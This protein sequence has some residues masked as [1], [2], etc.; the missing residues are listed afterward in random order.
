MPWQLYAIWVDRAECATIRLKPVTSGML[1]NEVMAEYP[2]LM[3]KLR[4]LHAVKPFDVSELSEALGKT[5]SSLSKF[6]NHKTKTLEGDQ[7]TIVESI[8]KIYNERNV[9]SQQ[10]TEADFKE[11]DIV[12]FGLQIGLPRTDIARFTGEQIPVLDAF[13][14]NSAAQIIQ[15]AKQISGVYLIYRKLRRNAG[16]RPLYVKGFAKIHRDRNLLIYED[17]WEHE[18]YNGYILPVG[19]VLNFI[20]EDKQA[21]QLKEVFWCGMRADAYPAKTLQGFASDVDAVT[22]APLAYEI[23]Y[24]RCDDDVWTEGLNSRSFTADENELGE[25]KWRLEPGTS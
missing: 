4:L 19:Q 17:H 18:N 7:R 20:S 10:I 9:L 5:Q 12:G 24:V 16:D 2:D 21:G 25:L 3:T 23:I 8:C 1:G 14:A 13:F 15:Y 11:Y 6:F 22:G